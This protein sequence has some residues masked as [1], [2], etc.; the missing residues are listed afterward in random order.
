MNYLLGQFKVDLKLWKQ[1]VTSD[2][3]LHR[4]AGMHF[5]RVW[6]N[7]DNPGEIFF[8]FRL[9]DVAVAKA[10]LEK[11]GALDKEKMKRGEIPRLIFLQETV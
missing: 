11:T 7:V 5:Q 9:E 8:L 6:R 10:F 4:E 3:A 2:T 1:V